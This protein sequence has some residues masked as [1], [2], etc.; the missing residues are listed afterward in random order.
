MTIPVWVEQQ[1]GKFT[2]SV[3]GVPALKAV[4]ETKDGAVLALRGEL[5]MRAS[6]GELVSVDVPPPGLRR[7]FGKYKD[8]PTWKEI[9]AEAYRCRDEL[10]AQDFPE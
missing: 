6:A 1:N 7:L 8:D 10:K 9:K 4:A 3:P 2:A 5:E